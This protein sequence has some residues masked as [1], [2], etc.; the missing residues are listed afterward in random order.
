MVHLKVVDFQSLLIFEE[1]CF[2]NW[3]SRIEKKVFMTCN[4]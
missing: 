4:F 3:K 1:K 2:K